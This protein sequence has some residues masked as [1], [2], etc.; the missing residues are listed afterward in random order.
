MLATNKSADNR[1][2]IS[3]IELQTAI[4][5]A[6]KKSDSNC[7]AFVDVIVRRL[8]PQSPIDPN[9]NIKGI[10]FGGCDRVKAAHAVAVIVERMQSEFR[11]E[12]NPRGGR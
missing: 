10:R 2:P 6:V 11:L 9:W 12:D 4:S 7:E 3:G 8:R 1:Q 5:E